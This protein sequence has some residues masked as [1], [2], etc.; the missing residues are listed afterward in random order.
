MVSSQILPVKLVFGVKIELAAILTES[1]Y[2]PTE[3]TK[4]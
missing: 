2:H 3:S 4:I 1:K